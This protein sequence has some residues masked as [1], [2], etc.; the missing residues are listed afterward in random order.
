MKVIFKDVGQ[1]D[2]IIIEWINSED[3]LQ[4]GIIDCNTFNLTNQ[5]IQHLKRLEN[6][7]IN[8]IVLSHPHEDHFSGLLDL[9]IYIEENLRKVEYF[10]HTCFSQKEYLTASVKSITSKRLLSQ[11]FKKADELHKKGIIANYCYANDFS[12]DLS[13]EKEVFLKFLYPSHSLINNY[14]KIAFRNLELTNN[15]PDANLLSTVIKIHCED[16]FLLLT[17]DA[18]KEVFWEINRKGYPDL[19]APKYLLAQVPHHGADNNYYE[20][21][22]RILNK[23]KKGVFACISVGPNSY[24][25]PSTRVLSS[26]ALS[27]YDPQ[28]TGKKISRNLNRVTRSLDMVSTLIT[29]TPNTT[30]DLSFEIVDNSCT[31]LQ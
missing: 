17:A 2:S 1:G 28:I 21:F 14:N 16:W 20:T 6:Y 31:L 9:L 3:R 22:W 29:S 24:G 12:R 19:L 7:D 15:N 10:L 11:I 23:T 8:F 4:I 26:L 5:V 30:D 27:N 25:H 13:L 18:S